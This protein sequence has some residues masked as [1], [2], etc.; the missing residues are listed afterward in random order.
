VTD[1]NV[2]V[3]REFNDAIARGEPGAVA[4][5][6]HRDVVW[7]HNIGV[8]SPEE[9]VYRGRDSLIRL[10]QRIIEPWE[11][12]RAEP[13][14][15]DRLEDGSYRV[16]GALHA[17]HRTSDMEVNASYEQCLEVRDGELVKGSMTTG[18]MA[19]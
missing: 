8:G 19:A 12:I 2:D 16:L 18:E 9:G 6:L 1:P 11:Y 15:I 14:S 4:E 10:M 7:E 17:K 13:R 5:H 3:I